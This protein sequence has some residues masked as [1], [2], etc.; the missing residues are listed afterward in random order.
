MMPALSPKL[1]VA[2][3]VLAVCVAVTIVLEMRNDGDAPAAPRGE[4]VIEL[5][6]NRAFT[7]RQIRDAI[8]TSELPFLASDGS[9][10]HEVVER[11]VLLI[12]AFYWDRGH[13][14]VKVGSPR[15][16]RARN[17]ISIPVEEGP[18]FTMGH[19]AVTGELLGTE[20]SHLAMINVKPGTLFSRAVIAK[21][22]ETL[23]TFYQDKSY[24]E[25]TVIPQTKVDTHKRT[26]DLTYEITTGKPSTFER[27]E[28]IADPP[29]AEAAIRNAVTV[30]AGQPFN[31]TQ[32]VETKRRVTALGFDTA[33][34]TARGADDTRVIV[35]IEAR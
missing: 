34:S 26:I 22:S 3:A 17:V 35:T 31:V 20:A 23:N 8:A 21:A 7:T 15:I 33:I 24:A 11:E 32:L 5:V 16:D 28:I 14:N 1:V 30:A 2:G 9:I 4:P 19:V 18:T 13:A 6:G 29:S 12:S 25:A 27:I 10:D